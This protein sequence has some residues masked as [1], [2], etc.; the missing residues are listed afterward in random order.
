[1]GFVFE[2]CLAKSFLLDCH[3]DPVTLVDLLMHCHG[4]FGRMKLYTL[5]ASASLALIASTT[6]AADDGVYWYADGYLISVNS[7]DDPGCTLVASYHDGYLFIDY[8]PIRNEALL[9][10]TEKQATSI[11]DGQEVNIKLVFVIDNKTDKG[12]G[13]LKTTA[14]TV[15][16]GVPFF[17]FKLNAKNLLKDFRT[18]TIVAFDTEDYVI[19]SAFKLNGSMVAE[20]KLRMCAFKQAGLNPN[21]PFLK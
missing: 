7:D 13:T 15:K 6:S 10:F 9:G 14:V 4:T 19:I 11:V 5:L 17:S 12:W 1:M 3:H 16:D 18:A 20:Q 8:S 21:D 2:H